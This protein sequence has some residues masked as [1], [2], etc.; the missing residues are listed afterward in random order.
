[1]SLRLE[2]IS[3]ASEMESRV[4]EAHKSSSSTFPW[5]ASQ[6]GNFMFICGSEDLSVFA[7]H[8]LSKGLHGAQYIV[9]AQHLQMLDGQ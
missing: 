5:R 8:Y 6:F 3:E 2:G 9:R 7:H 4:G 1:M